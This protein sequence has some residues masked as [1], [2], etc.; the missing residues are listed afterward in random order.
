ML[1]SLQLEYSQDFRKVYNNLDLISDKDFVKSLNIKSAKLKEYL[2]KEVIAFKE[3]YD[4]GKERL[5]EVIKEHEG[6]AVIN[7]KKLTSLR[8]SYYSNICFGGRLNL[9]RRTKG[10]ITKEE[11]KELRK[12][13]MVFYGETSRKGNRFFDFKDL[14]EGKVLFKLESTKIKIPITFSNRKHSKELFLLQEMCMNKEIPLTIKLTSDKIHISFDESKLNDTNFDHK[15][16]QKEKP[17][18]LS[19]EGTKNYWRTKFQEHEENLKQGKLD[20]YLAIDINPNEIGFVVADRDLEIIEHGCYKIEGKVSENKRK[21]EYSQIVKDLFTKVKHYRVSYFIIEDLENLNKDN[22]GNKISNRKN[23]LEF[24][25]NYI[26]S[27][28]TRRC[29]ETGTILRKVNPVY[30]SFIGNLTYDMYD[31]IASSIEICRRGINQFNKGFK[32]FPEY[33]LDNILTDKIDKYVDPSH[34]NTF[35]ELYKSIRDKSYRRKD[36][37]FSRQKFTQTDKSHVCLCF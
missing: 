28:V 30:S 32:L 5:A 4:S 26:F 20:R 12:Y 22:F 16:Y 17:K 35:R 9:Q 14:S 24:K 33:C 3:K 34:F 31:P 36:L 8:K 23:K 10:L 27:L 11:W 13:P 7:F 29:N 2:F 21:Y 18:H 6:R 37:S 1:N 25:K 19:K 15:L